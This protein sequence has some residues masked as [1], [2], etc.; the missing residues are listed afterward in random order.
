MIDLEINGTRLE[1]IDLIIFDKDGTL[2]QLYPYWNKMAML[3]AECICKRLATSEPGLAEWIALQMGVDVTK[4][5]MNPNGP[6]GIYGRDYIQDLL[7]SRLNERVHFIEKDAIQSAFKEADEYISQKERIGELHIPVNGMLELMRKIKGRCNG[8]ILSNDLSH[9]L[10]LICLS[11][12]ISSSFHMLLG[13]D[14]AL[15]PKPNPWGAREI[16]SALSVLPENTALIGDSITDMECGRDAGCGY[17]IAML[18]EVSNRDQ[19]LALADAVVND[20]REIEIY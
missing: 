8:A 20:F 3:R 5:R 7:C 16:M 9:K 15:H 18:S 14:R 1:N 4:Q 19:V 13:T 17:L 6:I 2:F 11:F 10:E 12:G